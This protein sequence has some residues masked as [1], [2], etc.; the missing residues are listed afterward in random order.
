[1]DFV[2]CLICGLV[3]CFCGLIVVVLIWIDAVGLMWVLCLGGGLRDEFG[4]LLCFGW[5]FV[6]DLS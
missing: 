1:M 3:V 5:V 4:L 6:V 2:Y